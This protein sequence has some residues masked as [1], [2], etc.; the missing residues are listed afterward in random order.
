ML[1]HSLW[2]PLET[3]FGRRSN[4]LDPEAQAIGQNQQRHVLTAVSKLAHHERDALLLV[5]VGEMGT[6]EAARVLGISPSAVKM[7]I[8]RARRSLITLLEKENEGRK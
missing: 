8:L 4:G 5:A 1:R 6:E 7:R 3:L 2:V